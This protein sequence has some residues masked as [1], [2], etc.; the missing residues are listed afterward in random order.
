MN[1]KRCH[2]CDNVYPINMFSKHSGTKD[3]LD[4]R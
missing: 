1:E 3:K 2:N 4:N